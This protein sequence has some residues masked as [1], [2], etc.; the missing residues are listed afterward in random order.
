MILTAQISS[1]VA[2]QIERTKFNFK[3]E[4]TYA[5]VFLLLC[6]VGV[7][8]LLDNTKLIEI[9]QSKIN[10]QNIIVE[11]EST[12]SSWLRDTVSQFLVCV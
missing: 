9:M 2:F 12:W 8:S 11:M 3:I 10:S 5:L 7:H 1:S 6:S 4:N